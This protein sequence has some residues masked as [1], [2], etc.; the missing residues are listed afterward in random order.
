MPISTMKK[1]TVL[2]FAGDAD[3]I[4]RKLM[5]LR[6]VEI[7]NTE[8]G[9]G[10]LLTAHLDSDG[11][12]ARAEGRLRSIREAIPLLNRYTT[13]R[14]SLGG[15]RHRVRIEEFLSDGRADSAWRTVEKAVEVST[16][17]TELDAER[18]RLQ[19]R[20][21]ALQPWLE[22]DL[23]L[24]VEGTAET[25]LLLGTCP[26]ALNLSALQDTMDEIGAYSEIVNADKSAV[27]LSVLFHKADTEKVNRA[28]VGF[29][30][31]RSSFADTPMN[32]STACE[33][34]EAELMRLDA[35]REQA[36]E[37]LSVL[38]ENLDE[39]EILCD[40]EEN[41]A[42]AARHL[43][44]LATTKKCAVLE[45]WI[46]QFT[47]ESVTDALS[48]FDCAYEIREPEEDEVPPVLLRNN[49]FAMNFE[50]VIG[51]YA[52]PKYGAFD[53]TFIMSI[54]YFVLFG[55]MFADVGYGLLL[56]IGCFGGIRL[57]KPR[58][59]MRRML[60][61]FGY[62]GI[63]SIIMGVI[64]GG[65]FGDLPTAIMTNMLGL[66][67][68]TGVGHFFGSG[69]WF[70]P[71]DDPMTFL[72]L[73]LGVGA[74]HLITGMIVKF[75]ILCRSGRVT[76]AL[77]TI[78]PYWVLFAGLFLLLLGM[79]GGSLAIAGT[80][81]G[82]VAIAGAVLILLLNGYGRKNI[83]SR[84]LGGFGGLY[85]LIN[86][87]SDLLSYSRILALG[88]VAGVIAKVINLITMLGA[89]GV[90]G[91]VFMVVILLVG[92]ALNLAIN[93]L[94]TFVHTSRLQYIEFFGKF[95]EDGGT[96]FEPA[97]TADRYTEQISDQS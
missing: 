30:F 24:A 87:A 28:L 57:F 91:F 67:V 22:Y 49:R 52:Y 96:P 26:P 61:M 5:N 65:W 37:W 43:K 2:A 94:G 60:S 72:I 47:R 25:V 1:L 27:Y 75:V 54:F 31:L 36:E 95:Y 23:P 71:L 4:V 55:L 76:E 83:F 86:Y 44:K 20:L 89:T 48:K 78:L 38:A 8:I 63:A 11:Q 21:E 6:C 40:V 74:I 14:K 88:L 56:A 77:C 69:L 73:S 85:G 51:M 13:R 15:S 19:A 66:N 82:Y 53:P 3:A 84:I 33:E 93:V 64:F 68:N 16:R 50:W 12:K 9:D 42:T 32:A 18:T 10:A 81:G 7:R 58:Q 79:L 17:M 35:E 41:N 29:G 46:P 59:G 39:V 70:N 92:H 62:C 97:S 45:G 80:V 34:T 90:V